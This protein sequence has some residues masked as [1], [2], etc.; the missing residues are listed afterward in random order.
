MVQVVRALGL[1]AGRGAQRPRVGRQLQRGAVR[2]GGHPPVGGLVAV[3][4][5]PEVPGHHVGA[6]AVGD[7]R[8][9]ERGDQRA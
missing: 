5:Q 3:A 4:R 1:L 7:D 6:G 8:H 9:G 2:E